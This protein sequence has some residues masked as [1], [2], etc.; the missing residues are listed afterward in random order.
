MAKLIEHMQTY[1]KNSTSIKD[2]TEPINLENE[3]QANLIAEIVNQFN[4]DT[5]TYALVRYE[6]Q[7]ELPINPSL[8]L[9][10][11]RGRIKAK[12][13]SVG[14]ITKVMLQI[15]LKS[16]PYGDAEIIEHIVDES[17]TVKFNNYYSIPLNIPDIL[18]LINTVKPAHLDF[19]YTYAYN[20]WGKTDDQA[21]IWNDG[22]TWDDLRTYKEV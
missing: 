21:I 3:N 5:A 22:G 16:M 20:W 6:E 17:F 10:E 14:T 7:Y 12:M 18:E 1:Y 13:Q 15:L 2:I 19:D 9:G 8:S 4:V 11:R